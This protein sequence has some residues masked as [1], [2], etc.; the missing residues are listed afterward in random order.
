MLKILIVDDEALIRVLI[1]RCINWNELGFEIV[2]EASNVTD[3]MALVKD[4]QPDVVFTDIMMPDIN[5]LEFAEM[6]GEYNPAVK[7]ILVSGYE[8]FE[9]AQRGIKLGVFDYILKPIDAEVLTR[10]AASVKDIITRERQYEQEICD[11]KE[12]LQ[13]NES[14]I[15][16]KAFYALLTESDPKN[17][18]ECFKYYNIS[19]EM[20][21]FQIAVV[22]PG[23]SS[24]KNTVNEIDRLVY[25]THVKTIIAEYIT[26]YSNLYCFSA[27]LGSVIILNNGIQENEF[28]QICEN[29]RTMLESVTKNVFYIGI[30]RSYKSIKKIHSSFQEAMEAVEYRYVVGM[31]H[32]VCYSEICLF[33]KSEQVSFEGYFQKISFY[34]RSG[35]TEDLKKQMQELFDLMRESGISKDEA[36]VLFIKS[37]MEVVPVF[38]SVICN[39]RSVNEDVTSAVNKIMTRESMA[40]QQEFIGNMFINISKSVEEQVSDKDKDV[41]GSVVDYVNLHYMDADLSLSAIA[42]AYFV[43]PSYLSR[44]F[45]DRAGKPFSDYLFEIRMENAKKLLRQTSMKAYEVAEKVGINDPSYFSVCFKKYTGKTIIQYKSES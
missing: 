32:T 10:V 43:N 13:R 3:G 6:I 9:Y 17:A 40:E 20:S 2:G 7:V 39:D 19:I 15:I 26:K 37:F 23:K 38:R 11:I 12:E 44:V 25:V 22:H 34:V 1:S 4:L 31:G 28:V 5:G 29:L 30:G 35:M 8:D 16:E 41:V 21:D 14:Y 18:L 36:T 42:S 24:E 45:K 27:D 33:D